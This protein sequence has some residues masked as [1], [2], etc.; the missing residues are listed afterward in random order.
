MGGKFLGFGVWGECGGWRLGFGWLLSPPDLLVTS[1]RI[2]GLGV[3]VI[4]TFALLSGHP[5]MN[6]KG[7]GAKPAKLS[8]P[9]A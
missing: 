5:K 8:N 4:I 9:V 3:L 2:L 1:R 7:F 6:I